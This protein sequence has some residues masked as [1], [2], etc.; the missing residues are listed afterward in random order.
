MVLVGGYMRC[1]ESVVSCGLNFLI[2]ELS[3]ENMKAE[4]LRFYI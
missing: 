3:V 1:K 2:K 4:V